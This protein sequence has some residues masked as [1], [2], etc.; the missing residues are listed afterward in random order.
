MTDHATRARE[1]MINELV[2]KFLSW[3]LPDSVCADLCAMKQGYPHRSGTTLLSA[4]EA[5]QMME[6]LF[7]D[8]IAAALDQAA[9][10]AKGYRSESDD[11]RWLREMVEDYRLESDNN[12]TAHRVAINT[13]IHKLRA[14]LQAAQ[15][16]WSKDK[17]T[18]AGWYWFRIAPGHM[19]II[20]RYDMSA[21][22]LVM[23]NNGRIFPI[24]DGEWAGP[25]PLPREATCQK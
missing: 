13:Y 22:G 23:W 5:K 4:I 11:E 15:P 9:Q 2:D 16:V 21:S 25:L 14:E 20:E 3:P 10:E 24:L 18:V 7:T 12:L 17:P 8:T 19:A 6:H 1:K